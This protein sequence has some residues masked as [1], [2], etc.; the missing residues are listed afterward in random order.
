MGS[1]AV[2]TD[3]RTLGAGNDSLQPSG[4]E[5]ALGP[6]QEWLMK[7]QMLSFSGAELARLSTLVAAVDK[8]IVHDSGASEG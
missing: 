1:A 3:K 6:N 4:P 2:A 5:R 8:E 7:N